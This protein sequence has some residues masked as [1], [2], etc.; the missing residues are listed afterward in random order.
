MPSSLL[1]NADSSG[2]CLTVGCLE[3]MPKLSTA[4]MI[5]MMIEK[6]GRK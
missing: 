3:K 6:V 5:G 4:A 2:I 1:T